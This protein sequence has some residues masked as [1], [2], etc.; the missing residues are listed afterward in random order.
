M[1]TAIDI[2][3]MPN[4]EMIS[5]LPDPEIKT[6]NIKDP[7]KIQAKMDAAREKQIAEMALSPLYGKI[8]CCGIVNKD[9]EYVE[10]GLNGNY[11]EI[12]IIEIL[13]DTVLGFH[14]DGNSTVIT[15]NGINFDIPFIYKRALMLGIKPPVS[16]PYWMKR[17]SNVPHC[18]LMQVWINW[19][20]K[21][22]ALDNVASVLLGQNKIEFDFTTIPELMK[23][24]AG[25]N[26][27]AKYCLQDTKLTYNI[28]NKFKGTLI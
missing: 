5:K 1:N 8:A 24:D 7:A 16:M 21:Y 25:R 3:T 20:G 17:Y 6:G 19:F 15:W 9:T 22:E 12:K 14:R 28:Y 2:E 27:I 11:N 10:F 23:T 13:F 26:E 4:P 18:D